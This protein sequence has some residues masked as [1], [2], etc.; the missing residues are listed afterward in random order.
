MNIIDF[1]PSIDDFN[2][3][4]F[5]EISIGWAKELEQQI[6]L[7]VNQKLQDFD[8]LQ[9]FVKAQAESSRVKF[10]KVDPA[11]EPHNENCA[12]YVC[13]GGDPD[14]LGNSISFRIDQN[15]DNFAN[16]HGFDAKIIG[17]L[18]SIFVGFSGVIIGRLDFPEIVLS[19]EWIGNPNICYGYNGNGKIINSDTV[20]KAISDYFLLAKDYWGVATIVDKLGFVWLWNTRNQKEFEIRPTGLKIKEWFQAELQNPFRQRPEPEWIRQKTA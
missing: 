1:P 8:D 7:L 14:S 20:Q 11:N 2:S 10:I 16:P 17:H 9:S 6:E 5:P 12:H 13:F 15:W 3:L 18:K 19:K 4:R